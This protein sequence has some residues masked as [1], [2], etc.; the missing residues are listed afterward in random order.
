MICFKYNLS[1]PKIPNAK[2]MLVDIHELRYLVRLTN[3][4]LPAECEKRLNRIENDIKKYESRFLCRRF[5]IGVAIPITS[6]T[7]DF[8]FDEPYF[9]VGCDVG[10]VLTFLGGINI[11]TKNIYLGVSIDLSTPLLSLSHNFKNVLSQ[12]FHLPR[13]KKDY[14]YYY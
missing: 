13:G 2:D 9:V 3:M 1:N 7:P 8:D 5:S 14:Y 6:I 11:D 10:D 12:L 4:R